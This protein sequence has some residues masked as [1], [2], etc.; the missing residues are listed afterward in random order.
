MAVPN[1]LGNKNRL[2]LKTTRCVQMQQSY[3]RPDCRP[4]ALADFVGRE[5][6]Q[7]EASCH[8]DDDLCDATM[9]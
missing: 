2:D 9:L 7:I 5:F 4:F 3:F 8:A 6:G 1:Q